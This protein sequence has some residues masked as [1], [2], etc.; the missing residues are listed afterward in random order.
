MGWGKS[1]TMEGGQ[2]PP[3][4]R[5]GGTVFGEEETHWDTGV[6]GHQVLLWGGA[7]RG[8]TEEQD[9]G[10]AAPRVLLCCRLWS[11]FPGCDLR[12]PP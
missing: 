12:G 2:G 9:S 4:P 6:R 5:A 7:S 10:E 3:E 11:L 8:G 1:A